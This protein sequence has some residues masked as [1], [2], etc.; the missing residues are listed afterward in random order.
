[1]WKFHDFSITQILREI[2]FRESRISKTAS[3]GNFRGPETLKFGQFQPLK[4]A[5]IHKE[6]K[7]RASKCVG[8]A[9]FALLEYT[10]LISRKIWLIE[11]FLNFYTVAVAVLPTLC[12]L[13]ASV[14]SFKNDFIIKMGV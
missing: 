9:D 6:S 1:M 2:K 13:A 14:S 11:K 10:K 8:I 3:F 7:F 5:K 12:Y 4:S